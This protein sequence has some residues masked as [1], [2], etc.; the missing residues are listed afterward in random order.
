[1]KINNDKFK[2]KNCKLKFL[3]EQLR[4]TVEV[5]DYLDKLVEYCMMKLYAIA[6]VE[7]TNQTWAEED[8]FQVIK[9]NINVKVIII[10][11]SKLKIFLFYF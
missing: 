1:M 9:P 7:E 10:L 5:D 4:L 11:I 2:F 6:S 3:G 8:D